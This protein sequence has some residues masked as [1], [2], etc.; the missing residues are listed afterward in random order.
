MQTY[1]YIPIGEVHIQNIRLHF[2]MVSNCHK[3]WY[4]HL[5]LFLREQY[6]FGKVGKEKLEEVQLEIGSE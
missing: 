5:V 2:K 1:T 3:K 6:A 4:G